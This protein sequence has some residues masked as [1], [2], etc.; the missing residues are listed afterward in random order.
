VSATL[1]V[2]TLY[3][4]SGRITEGSVVGLGVVHFVVGAKAPKARVP[5]DPLFSLGSGAAAPY[6]QLAGSDV[7][8]QLWCVSIGS[9]ERRL[10]VDHC[11]RSGLAPSVCNLCV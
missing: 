9:C 3:F 6:A 5:R 4:G 8:W 1:T 10:W 2:A 7:E 11:W